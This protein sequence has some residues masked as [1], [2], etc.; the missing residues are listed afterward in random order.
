[1]TIVLACRKHSK[2]MVVTEPEQ[3]Q[4]Q[5]HNGSSGNSPSSAAG[6]RSGRSDVQ[7]HIFGYSK[8]FTLINSH[9]Y[10]LKEGLLQMSILQ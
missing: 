7:L 10:P 4:W 8:H 2:G 3:E 9:N 6:S 5:S 1:M